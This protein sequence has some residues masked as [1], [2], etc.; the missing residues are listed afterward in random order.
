MYMSIISMSGVI[1]GNVAMSFVK[2]PVST[3]SGSSRIYVIHIIEDLLLGSHHVPNTYFTDF[4]IELAGE[5]GRF[6]I[7]MA[8]FELHHNPQYDSVHDRLRR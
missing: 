7:G 4:T 3:K 8:D 5:I 1:L 2:L 6:A